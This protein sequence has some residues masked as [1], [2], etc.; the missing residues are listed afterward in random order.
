MGALCGILGR[1]DS[2]ALNAMI[3][4]LAPH[5]REMRCLEGSNYSVASA[6]CSEDPLCLVDGETTDINDA[7]LK[8]HEVHARCAKAKSPGTLAFRGGFAAVVSLSDGDRW[9]LLRDRLGRKPLYYYVGDNVLVFATE[10]KA[11]LASGYVPRRLNLVAVDRYL[12]LRCVPGTESMVQGICRVRPGHV[13]EYASNRCSSTEFAT[14]NMRTESLSRDEAARALRERLEKALGHTQSELLLW[15]SG[16]DAAALHAL[17]PQLRPCFAV[18]E[19]SWQDETRLAKESAKSLHIRMQTMQARRFTEETFFRCVACLDEPIADPLV[20]PLWLMTEAA[21]DIGAH[22]LSGHGADEVLGGYARYHFL[23]KA[24]EVEPLIP[25]G[26]L[27][28][29]TPSLPPNAFVRRTTRFLTS[30]RD[31]Q[32]AYLSLLSVFDEGEREDL[33]TE[34]VKAALY[35]FGPRKSTIQ[36]HFN[37][38]DLTAN[39]LSLDLHVGLPNI[40]LAKCDR[41]AAAHGVTLSHPYL[42]DSMLDFALSIP[43]DIK[44]GVRSKPLLRLAMKGILPPSIRLRA[45]RDFK[46][47]QSGNVLR[48]IET[49]TKETITPDRVDATGLFKWHAVETILRSASHNVYRRR[50]FWALLM[51]FAWYRCTMET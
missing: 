35:E 27:S 41:I 24:Q 2:I 3:D 43:S 17:K 7:P 16:I 10:L 48:V 26:L 50:Q 30:M 51:F 6:Y 29:I 40:L 49:V 34:A 18:L 21:S 14:F 13:V 36:D 19:R 42:N 12:T 11:L 15:S 44:F 1:S 25:A 22:F 46:V 32:R 45:R 9:W 31:P 4:V 20:F 8:P 37:Q 5:A 28:N 23:Q 38:E 47:P 33:Y 39:V